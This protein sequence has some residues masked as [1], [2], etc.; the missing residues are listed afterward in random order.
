MSL[1]I[2]IVFFV[3]SVSLIFI[4]L[5]IS[6]IYLS[7]NFKRSFKEQDEKFNEEKL[8]M[9]LQITETQISSKEEERERILA[10]FHDD[11]NPLFAVL[12][13]QLRLFESDDK[14]KRLNYNQNEQIS[15]LIDRI[16]ENQNT[17]IG[18]VESKVQTIGQ[19]TF[20]IQEYLSCL[21]SYK[22]NFDTEISVKTE[23]KTEIL[24]NF[25][26]IFLELIH[27]LMKHE[28]IYQLNV[29]L[30]ID[31]SSLNLIFKH[32]GIGLTNEQFQNSIRLKEG[33]GLSSIN[34]R[35]NIIG[36]KMNL[37]TLKDGAIIH[38]NLPLKNA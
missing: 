2:I 31:I 9:Q 14:E 20:A 17:A 29:H 30:N 22:I 8:D 3:I 5:I 7:S 19:L 18:K 24:N 11:I 38:I 10:S 36:A 1:K 35:L 25:Y 28:K 4:G 12:K 27:N 16:I 15:N 13:Y 33:R 32:D 6:I 34:S 37:M 26:S 21:N 23:L